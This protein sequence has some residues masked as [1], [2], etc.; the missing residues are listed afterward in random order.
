MGTHRWEVLS[1]V[2]LLVV[3]HIYLLEMVRVEADR[4]PNIYL[5]E[6]V[7]VEFRIADHLLEVAME[8]AMVW[9]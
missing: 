8:V 9:A 1:P 7:R 6:M 4:P 2:R 5:L 3:P